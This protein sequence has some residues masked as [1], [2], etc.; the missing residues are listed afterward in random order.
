MVNESKMLLVLMQ[1]IGYQCILIKAI[2]VLGEGPTNGLDD[3]T[4]TAEAKNSVNIIN[5][6]KEICLSLHYN[7]A[8][9]FLYANGVQ[10]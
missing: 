4:I 1:K 3:T 7:G 9:S 10:I 6:K 2:L 5:S 8:N